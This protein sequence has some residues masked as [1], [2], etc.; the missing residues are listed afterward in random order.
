MPRL[1]RLFA[2]AALS[3]LAALLPVTAFANSLTVSVFGAQYAV[4]E[5]CTDGKTSGTISS[6]AGFG[7]VIPGGQAA[8]FQTT[9]CHTQITHD[10]AQILGGSFVLTTGSQMLV[11]QYVR[12][13]VEPGVIT[14]RHFCKEVFPVSAMFAP[15]G[16]G[17]G[18]KGWLTHYG[19][20]DGTECHAYAAT[21]AG[22]AQFV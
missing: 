20:R 18:A 11:G 12:G 2:A 1:N 5:P 14:G 15:V 17:A 19:V 9:I 3:T 10:G 6:F 4:G 21:I 22:T 16:S 7:R 13:L 8:V